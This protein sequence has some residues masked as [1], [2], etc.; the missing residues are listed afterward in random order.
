MNYISG[1]A[2]LLCMAAAIMLLGKLFLA[3]YR[4]GKNKTSFKKEFENPF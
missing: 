1:A 4:W 2:N 3:V